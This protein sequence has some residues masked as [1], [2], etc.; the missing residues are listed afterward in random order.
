MARTR[1]FGATLLAIC[2]TATLLSACNPWLPTTATD[3]GLP[4]LR[5][6]GYWAPNILAD[7]VTTSRADVSIVTQDS[8]VITV[9]AYDGLDASFRNYARDAVN[10][11][12]WVFINWALDRFQL[13][14][15]DK[16]HPSSDADY[17]AFVKPYFDQTKAFL[18]GA[19]TNGRSMRDRVAMIQV[20]DE[21][22]AGHGCFVGDGR[23]DAFVQRAHAE[24][25][26]GTI[27]VMVNYVFDGTPH[28]SPGVDL[29]GVDGPVP[30][31]R[32]VP[33]LDERAVR[34]RDANRREPGHLRA[35][36]CHLE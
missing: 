5:L 12:M 10:N 28:I 15:R 13:C 33:L 9:G 1:R 31:H 34:T 20:A 24:L 4:H 14:G 17:E 2:V 25:Q 19:Y 36:W 29:V 16:D 11:P 18:D 32:P 22:D 27:P 3:P 7:D 6:V 21:V 8:N 35:R 26:L 23:I 30:A